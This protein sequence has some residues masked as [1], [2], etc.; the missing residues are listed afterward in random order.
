[1][2]EPLVSVVIGTYNRVHKLRDRAMRS[3]QDQTLDDWECIIVDAESSDG[4]EEVVREMAARDPRIRY[5]RIKDEGNSASKNFGIRQARGRFIA[6]TDDDD[7]FL[8]DYFENAIEEFKK[9]PPDVGFLSGGAYILDDRGKESYI[10]PPIEPFWR[11][12]IGNGWLFR[13]ECFFDH[14]VFFDPKLRGFEDTDLRIRMNEYFKG[15]IMDRPGRIYY[16]NLEYATRNARSTSVDTG[17]QLANGEAFLLKNEERYRAY[18]DEAIAYIHLFLGL[19]NL[20]AGR[21]KRGRMFLRSSLR[22]EFSMKTA[23]F[24]I[25]AAFGRRSFML[26]DNVKSRAMRIVRML[27]VDPSPRDERS[28]FKRA[29]HRMVPPVYEWYRRELVCETAGMASILDLGCGFNSYVQHLDKRMHRVGVELFDEYVAKSKEKGIHNEY[30]SQ[31]LRDLSRF[32]S[33]SFDVVYSS[34]VI[35]HL[36]KEEG[37]RFAKEMERIARKKVIISTPNGFLPQ[38][39]YDGNDMQEHKSGWTPDEF[40]SMGYT[41]K[42]M[43]GWKRLRTEESRIRFRPRAFWSFVANLTQPIVYRHP[44]HA[45]SLFAVKEIR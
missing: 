1:M 39:S 43:D 35:E 7:E 25:A 2:K 41:A 33:R 44:G 18:G 4:T 15:H 13:R 27:V 42:G 30:V 21:M 16:L 24:L 11:S 32:A 31:D 6:L 20:R 37:M 36:T 40:R 10:L 8:P 22:H 9:L 17:H 14:G 19:V 34:D 3:V 38:A 26:F 28:F 5:F 29:L 12:P 45:H 23:L